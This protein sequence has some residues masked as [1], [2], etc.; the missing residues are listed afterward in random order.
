[1]V[2][3]VGYARAW[4]PAPV[5]RG[6]PLSVAEARERDAA[7]LPY[8]AVYREPGGEDPPRWAAGAPEAPA[9]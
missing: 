6:G 3:E 8:V 7:G 5:R 1:M 4:D 2:V 9:D